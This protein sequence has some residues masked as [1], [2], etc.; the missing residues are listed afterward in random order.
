VAGAAGG[1]H[2]PGS[3]SRQVNADVA[4]LPE[5]ACEAVSATSTVHQVIESAR[6]A[7]LRRHGRFNLS[8]P[9]HGPR[10]HFVNLDSESWGG[11]RALASLM[12]AVSRSFRSRL[13]SAAW[14]STSLRR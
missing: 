9:F 14:L 6:I 3:R 10:A 7:T 2:R 8:N 13:R 4:A 5:D 12:L 1:L 11:F